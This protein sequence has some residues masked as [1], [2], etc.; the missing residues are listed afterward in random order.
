[1]EDLSYLE[2]D[3]D[4]SKLT[5]PQLRSLLGEHG[6]SELPPAS[7]KKEALL[8]LFETH[9]RGR[10]EEIRKARRSVKASGKGIAFLDNQSQPSP[11]PSLSSVGSPVKTESS[12]SLD[13]PQ[14][15]AEVK[16]RGRSKTTIEANGKRSKS[17]I[18]RSKSRVKTESSSREM[19]TPVKALSN[20]LP[21]A[22]DSP[23]AATIKLQRRLG[24]IASTNKMTLAQEAI[25]NPIYATLPESK[26]QPTG[27]V[28]WKIFGTLSNITWSLIKFIAA[29]L[30]TIGLAVYLRWKYVYP[31]PYCDTGAVAKPMWPEVDLLTSIRNLC[32]A[33]PE[34]G[35]CHNGKLYCDEGHVKTSNWVFLG[36]QC[37]VDWKRFSKA[38]DLAKKIKLV[39]RERQGNFQCGLVSTPSIAE[40]ALKAL[41][42]SSRFKGAPWA[43]VDFDS[44]WRLAVLDLSKDIESNNGIRV[45]GS[46]EDQPRL[47]L[48]TVA[49]LSYKC[50]VKL[51]AAQFYDQYRWHLTLSIGFLLLSITAY[52]KWKWSRAEAKQV[53]ELVQTVLQCLAE[54]D[55]LNR[56]D[57]TRPSTLSVPQL[58]DALFMNAKAGE[59][60]RLWPR[61]CATIATNSNVRE[62]VMSMKGEQHRVWEWIGQDVLAPFTAL[63]S[64]PPQ[65][66]RSDI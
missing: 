6:V 7:A 21:A 28:S 9:V 50:Q 31:L 38:E 13:V 62:S 25:N 58:R 54:Q 49:L 46:G 59:K 64:P 57:P 33:C 11:K 29:F 53:E 55:A 47:F 16:K 39:L 1:M 23:M 66:P 40:P 30:A 42:Q 37:I 32:L 44:Y 60:A 36:E 56:R 24:Y 12:S 51:L 41:L 45:M 61:V 2:A 22:N 26:K 34:H 5:K 52:L 8:A 20:S 63:I 10:A 48:S 19:S 65:P 43:T 17:K 18:S 27:S 14:K 35:K 4:A 3:Y 15:S